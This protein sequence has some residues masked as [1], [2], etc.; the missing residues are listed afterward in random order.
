[1][2]IFRISY[3]ALM[4]FKIDNLPMVRHTIGDIVKLYHSLEKS[5]EEDNLYIVAI[6]EGAFAN[7]HWAYCDDNGNLCNIHTGKDLCKIP[8]RLM[9]WPENGKYP[10]E[11]FDSWKK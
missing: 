10:N 6:L 2:K 7:I 1:M 3:R 8:D 4:H 11:W 9:D 5:A